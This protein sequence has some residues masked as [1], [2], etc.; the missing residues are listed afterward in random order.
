MASNRPQGGGSSSAKK[1]VVLDESTDTSCNVLYSIDATGK[2]LPKTGT[3][4]TFNSNTGVLTAT[5]LVGP[6]TGDVTGNTSGTSGSTTGNAATATALATPRAIGGVNFDGSAAIT[7]PGVNSAGNQAT[8][9]LAATATALA[10]ARTIGGTSFDGTGNIAITTNADL[11]GG[12]TS[13][14]NAA[15]V[16]TNANLTGGVTSVGNAATVVTNAN[17]TGDVTSSGNATTIAVDAV[18]IAMI[19]AS[20][21]AGSSTFLRGD[22]SWAAAGGDYEHGATTYALQGSV[23]SDPATD[24]GVMYM[25]DIDGNNEGL[26]MKVKKNGAVVEVQIL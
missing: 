8:S 3:N 12:V 26:F 7:L 25:K 24:K 1:I 13:S 14:G 20:G 6:L 10:T 15:T 17:L 4:L 5:G 22:N 9:G 19:S 2:I 11:T 21:T 23:P 16:I 18:D